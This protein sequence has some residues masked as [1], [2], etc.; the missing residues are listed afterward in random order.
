MDGS[1]KVKRECRVAIIKLQ[2][3]ARAIKQAYPDAGRLPRAR[4]SWLTQA[5]KL[6]N[7]G[8]LN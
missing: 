1:E 4:E 8:R 3:V 7:N 2:A 6:R 5:R